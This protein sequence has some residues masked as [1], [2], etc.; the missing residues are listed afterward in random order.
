[1]SADSSER[2][3]GQP[4]SG[5]NDFFSSAMEERGSNSGIAAGA[6]GRAPLAFRDG[7]KGQLAVWLWAARPRTLPAAIVPVI[8]GLALA[9]RTRPIDVPLGAATLA[10]ALLI[11]IGTNLA[12]DYYDFIAG[13]DAKGRLGPLRITQ[14][15]LA[16][17]AAVK[18]AAFG[19]LGLAAILGVYLSAAGGWPIL[20]IGVLALASANG[21]TAGPYPL[22][23]HGLGEPFAFIFFGLVAVTGTVYLQTGQVGLLS[24]LA[25]LPVACLVTAILVVNNV[26]DIAS[27]SKACKRTLAVRLGENAA[28]LE[29]V[30]LVGAAFAALGPICASAGAGPA[31]AFMALP[32]AVSEVRAFNARTGAALNQSLAGTARLHLI[33][34]LLL[35][36]GLLI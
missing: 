27:D 17:P 8:V 25:S 13:A 7:F 34:G 32:L 26:R 29:Y 5:A 22:A 21:Y 3:R 31:L 33:F 30:A 16:S 1:M 4:S 19:V 24:F 11:Q 18:R 9:R 20:A 15:G 6:G 28:R 10:A 35:A 2:N 14:A 36:L 23:Y 12:N